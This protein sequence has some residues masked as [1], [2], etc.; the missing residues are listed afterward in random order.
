MPY[1]NIMTP[2]LWL[3]ETFVIILLVKVNSEMWVFYCL[4]EA[5]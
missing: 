1:S 5:S 2:E 3:P 4:V